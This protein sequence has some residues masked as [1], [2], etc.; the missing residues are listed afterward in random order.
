MRGALI[1][2]IHSRERERERERERKFHIRDLLS[3]CKDTRDNSL[4]LVA[5]STSVRSRSQELCSTSSELCT[6]CII[7]QGPASERNQARPAI[8]R[9]LSLDGRFST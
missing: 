3:R 7:T 9:F 4:R 2:D 1:M 6:R 5:F 8:S